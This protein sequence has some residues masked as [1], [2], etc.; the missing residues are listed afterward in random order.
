MQFVL[1]NGFKIVNGWLHY[2]AANAS[3]THFAPVIVEPGLEKHFVDICSRT[4]VP[5]GAITG[6][7]LS[8][9]VTDGVNFGG[10]QLKAYAMPMG[11]AREVH[12]R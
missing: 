5:E 3:N 4:D 10:D 9:D 2:A 7:V 12:R 11:A 1:A 8:N 6:G